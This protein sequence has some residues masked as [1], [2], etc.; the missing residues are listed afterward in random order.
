MKGDVKNKLLPQRRQEIFL[1]IQPRPGIGGKALLPG[2]EANWNQ[3]P[4]GRLRFVPFPS[5]RHQLRR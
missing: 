1:E 5:L 4:T 3:I 2:R